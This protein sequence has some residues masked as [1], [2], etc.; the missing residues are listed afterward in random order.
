[1]I[2][3]YRFAIATF[4]FLLAGVAFSPT[5]VKAQTPTEQDC[6]G[7]IPICDFIWSTGSSTLGS[8][9]YLNEIGPGTCLTAGELNSTWFTF[10]VIESGDLAFTIT[11]IDLNA[12]YDWG[13]YNLTNASCE[14]IPSDGSLM[15]SC[16]SS[17]YGVTG[18]SSSGIGNYNGPGPTFAFNY[19]LP[20]VSGQT[21]AL[22]IHNWSTSN[23]G[24]S[25]DFSTATAT[26]FDT[27]PPSLQV[28][29]PIGC[30]STSLTFTFS[31]NILCNTVEVADFSL[32]G[33]GGPFII[34]GVS[35]FSCANGGTQEKT[36]TVTF[37][38]A[39]ENG[40]TYTFGLTDLAG[41]VTD[42]CGNIADTS[43][44]IFVAPGPLLSVD[45]ILQP[46]CS[47][48]SGA[49][50]VSGSVGIE[51]YSYTLNNGASQTNGNF[52]ELSAGT[53]LLIVEDSA[54]CTD[55]LEVI[56]LQGPGGVTAAVL[57]ATDLKCP[58]ECTGTITATGN[59]GTEPYTYA[60]SNGGAPAPTIGNLCAGTYIATI[61]DASGCFDTASV[62]L[63][64]PDTFVVNIV[65]L[66]QPSCNGTGD[67]SITVSV[68]GGSPGYTYQW[69]PSGGNGLTTNAI[70][71]GLYTITIV[72]AN[73][74]TFSYS[75]ALPQPAP[76]VIAEPA[77]TTICL[78]TSGNLFADVSGG[79]APYTVKW[80]G[81]F[82]G[83]PFMVTPDEDGFYTAVATDLHGCIS[84][85]QQFKVIVDPLPTVNLGNDSLLCIDD[86]LYLSAT[87]PG[88]SYN[89]QDG[90][91]DSIFTISDAGIYWVNVYNTCFSTSDTL[92]A[93]YTDC[94]ACVHYPSGF[95]PDGNQKNDL[96]R[97]VITCPV[98][99][100]NMQIFNRW[101]EL[102][103]ETSNVNESWDGRYKNQPGDIGVYVW[104]VNYTGLRRATLF[105]E[106]LS[107]NVTLIR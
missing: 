98:T 52:T 84:S 85:P 62:T 71:A 15:A 54:G 8:G 51:P 26:I 27:V 31:E 65:Q 14:D 72:D 6:L 3:L 5:F 28:V 69:S 9:N 90:S 35:G 74:C 77:D 103:F 78:G 46:I 88:A 29:T 63:Q 45:S 106:S 82:T 24:Y 39:L 4:S 50:Y 43:S 91:T 38:P 17:Q 25:I 53:Y 94:S 81:S 66:I 32:E 11:P 57:S 87:F 97:P 30:N 23:G 20:V 7:A 104:V 80:D 36:F 95:S 68:T 10:T 73:F 96:F 102:I 67:G 49:I 61:T 55:S 34:S 22:N 59:G 76:V 12:D 40:A 107:G 101:G 75:I 42:L 33:P 105:S 58:N 64:Q 1:M 99:E 92:V 70:S 89:W 19:L 44:I 47:A 13:L 37:S 56:L 83:N 100:Y 86:K 48:N 41:Y 2:L 93:E 79:T 60:W 21:Y 16:N 18:I